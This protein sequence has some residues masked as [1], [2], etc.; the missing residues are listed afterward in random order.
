MYTSLNILYR[1]HIVHVSTD[2]IVDACRTV[3]STK[4]G[5]QE[6]TISNDY[7][8]LPFSAFSFFCMALRSPSVAIS[9]FNAMVYISSAFVLLPSCI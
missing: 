8:A 3:Y 1:N 7:F 4:A 5:K 6:S 2:Y 9:F